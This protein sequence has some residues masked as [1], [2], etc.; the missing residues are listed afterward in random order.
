MGK[1]LV[2]VESPAKARTINK[3]LG[4]NFTVKASMGHVRDL[5]KKNLGVDEKHDF[6]PTYEILPGRKKVIDE[7]KKV[8]SKAD[9]VFLAPDPDREGEAIC[10]HLSE[11]LRR[12]NRRL[13]RVMFNEITRRAVLQG[14]QNP[15]RID[16]HKVDAQ[17]ARR[18][19]DRLVGYKI[20]PLLWDKV[21]RGLS[22]GRV[23]SV[24]LRIVV[25]R[26]RE[27]QAFEP[28][29]YWTLGALLQGRVPPPFESRLVKV[30]GGKADLKNREQTEAVVR[31]LR[32]A[33]FV[34]RS[35]EGKEKRK[36]P[37]PPFI[38][39]KLQQ[40][41][42]R[43]LGFSVRKTM[44]LAQRLYEGMDLGAMG[45]VG[46]ITYM[47]TD[48]T[49]V[50]PEALQEVR[51]HIAR[52]HGPDYLPERPRAFK[53]GR[54]AQ[55]A[56]EAIRPTSM[57]LTPD[58]VKSFLQ[59]DELLLYGLIWNRFVASQMKPAVFDVTT[60]DID[61][62]RCL[63]RATGSVMRFPGYLAVYQEI[64]ERKTSASAPQEEDEASRALPPLSAGDVLSLKKLDPR[65][66]FT[67]P[68]PR[69]TEASLVK[70]L[71]E[72]GIGRPSTYATILSTLQ[73]REYVQKG[74]G[75]F[76]PTEL[77]MTVTDLL[78]KHFGDIVDVGYTASMEEELDRIEEG[79]LDYVKALKD[80]NRQFARDLRAAS[81]NMENIKTKEEP[82]DRRCE[83][84]GRPM[85]IKWG[86]YGRFIACSGYPEC[87]N[88]QEL[89][90]A[91][92]GER[93]GGASDRAAEAPA[94]PEDH[95]RCE[96]CGSVM[97]LRKGRF[98][99]FIACSAYPKCRNTKKIAVDR[100]GRITV[101]RKP[102]RPLDERCPRCGKPLVVRDGRFGEF[103]A[104]SAYPECRFIKLKEV[105][106]DCPRPGCRG[107]VVERRSRRGRVFFGCSDYPGCE[108]VSWY[109]PIAQS[110][111]SCG[112]PYVL[113]KVTKRHGITHFCDSEGCGFKKAV[114]S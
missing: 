15:S 85:V 34:V 93:A 47:R 70:E 86:R 9:R 87:K 32:E 20:S 112:R 111:P 63:F 97:V 52:T 45:S 19:L 55:G 98:G 21:R 5:P 92:D 8:A 7:L 66:H 40:D 106:L 103:T 26:E 90:V 18:I 44:T 35:V 17:Q 61:A 100:E 95:G 31:S 1:S 28:E 11:L 51:E 27:I 114:N 107:R 37:V 83:K 72:N 67:Q 58:R 79:R 89:S 3:F 60:V 30:D 24:A 12:T 62:A 57:E 108:F 49:R 23:Q 2:I 75:K 64:A 99:P 46:L 38:T 91:A 22:A 13:H 109:R 102:D 6:K 10:W 41:A 48:S 39:S 50:A 105:G 101:T 29:E 36:N 68:P 88:T 65:Q 74:E 94:I 73:N 76:F 16:T 56:H 33:R 69:F 77:G 71:E 54:M 53:S 43:K 96:K 59:R 80:F 14:I 81:L 84:C 110:C 42:S 82:T 104:C 78:V 25:E 113:E 4:R